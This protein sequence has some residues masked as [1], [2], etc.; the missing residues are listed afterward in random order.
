MVLTYQKIML[1]VFEHHVYGLVFQNDLLECDYVFMVDFA[2]Q[3]PAEGNITTTSEPDVDV[4]PF[5]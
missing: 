3:L 2:V 1:C 4:P 5:L